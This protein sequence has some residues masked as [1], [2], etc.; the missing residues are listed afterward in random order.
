MAK[1]LLKINL[2]AGFNKISGFLSIDKEPST[3]PD[4]L[5]DLE[6]FPWIWKTNSVINVIFNHSLEHLGQMVDTYKK[7]IKELYRICIDD[8]IIEIRAPWWRH[9]HWIADPTHVRPITPLGLALLSKKNNEMWIKMGAANS[10]LALW[11]GV[12]FQIVS[13]FYVSDA[14]MW[15][16]TFPGIP[17]D[18]INQQKTLHENSN[19]N[20]LVCELQFSLVTKKNT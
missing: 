8:A 1:K 4:V 6:T 3:K 16:R 18:D 17:R 14:T 2:G 13:L 7:I 11:W 12:D 19:I 15:Q 20:N 10:S 9:D 5:F